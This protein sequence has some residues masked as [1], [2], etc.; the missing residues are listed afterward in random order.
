MLYGMAVACQL[1]VSWVLLHNAERLESSWESAHFHEEFNMSL[2]AAGDLLL[3]ASLTKQRKPV[4]F[5]HREDIVEKCSHQA[6]VRFH[7]FYY[8]MIFVWI[9]AILY[10][11][12][13]AAALM[14]D[15]FHV[16]DREDPSQ[17][18]FG[19]KDPKQR[20]SIVRLAPLLRLVVIILVPCMRMGVCIAI[21]YSG[22]KFLMLQK[23][24][25]MLVLKALC[26][27]FVVQIDDVFLTGMS[28]KLAKARLKQ[29][30]IRTK[31]DVL[32]DT[33]LK[34][35]GGGWA[36]LFLA[37]SALFIMTYLIF[38]N[39]MYFRKWCVEYRAVFEEIQGKKG[40]AWDKFQRRLMS[41]EF[42]DLIEQIFD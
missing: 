20:T 3:N 12:I 10:E 4:G 26:M 2:A 16:A 18:L 22:A 42:D 39:L 41:F 11:F 21:G 40:H 29:T 25:L 17:S 13:C 28:T 19:G 9:S 34:D 30:T 33:A 24:E 31:R 37:F 27:Q 7:W 32:K 14:S 8:I 36:L 5:E 6:H 23:N 1:V 15:I 35:G 38:G